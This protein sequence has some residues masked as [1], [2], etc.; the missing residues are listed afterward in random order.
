MS[1]PVTRSNDEAEYNEVCNAYATTRRMYTTLNRIIEAKN[2]SKEGRPRDDHIF[3]GYQECKTY[4]KTSMIGP[5]GHCQFNDHF[6]GLMKCSCSLCGRKCLMLS[7]LVVFSRD[8]QRFYHKN[9]IE[10]IFLVLV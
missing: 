9:T 6:V 2:E 8:L 1:G 3:Q 4:L 7:I 10:L 5:M